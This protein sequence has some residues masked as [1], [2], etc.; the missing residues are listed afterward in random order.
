[1]VHLGEMEKIPLIRLKKKDRGGA[2][3]TKS[4][5]LVEEVAGMFLDFTIIGVY[6]KNI[7]EIGRW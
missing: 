4:K 6:T 2:S 1:M 5:D 7:Y 3:L